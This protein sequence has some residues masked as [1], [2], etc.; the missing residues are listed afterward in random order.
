MKK[1][2]ISFFLL[3][4]TNQLFC[5]EK[6]DNS[7]YLELLG[8]GGLYSFNYEYNFYDSLNARIG[9][10]YSFALFEMITIPIMINYVNPQNAISPEIGI[11][12]TIGRFG[13]FLLDEKYRVGAILTGTVGIRFH[14]DNNRLIKIAYTPLIN[15][16]SGKILHFGGISFGK[17]F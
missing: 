3:I 1:V 5:Q 13:G 6:N 4:C 9:L 16:E 2:Y 17:R 14:N 11:G 12:F 7:F 10:S 8:N 15:L